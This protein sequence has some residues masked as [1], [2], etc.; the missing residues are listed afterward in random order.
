M[1]QLL[2]TAIAEG[3]VETVESLLE[4][5]DIVHQSEVFDSEVILRFAVRH[6]Q[7]KIVDLLLTK[8]DIDVNTVFRRNYKTALI[9]AVEQNNEELVNLL[10]MRGAKLDNSTKVKSG[11]YTASSLLCNC[12]L[13]GN[14]KIVAILLDNGARLDFT[15]FTE[16]RQVMV[17]IVS[18]NRVD[19]FKMLINAHEDHLFMA[20]LALNHA[21]QEQRAEFIEKIADC[22]RNTRNIT[23]N[24]ISPIECNNTLGVKLLL[25][26]F[27]DLNQ[28]IFFE[29]LQCAAIWAGA[30][31][32]YMLLEARS[33]LDPMC[34]DCPALL[35]LLHSIM[36]LM[37]KLGEIVGLETY[38]NNLKIIVSHIVE[39]L[40]KGGYVKVGKR[41]DKNALLGKFK[42]ECEEELENMKMHKFDE[43]NISLY[44]IW[45]STNL[46]L[47]AYLTNKDVVGSLKLLAPDKLHSSFPIY[48]GRIV[49]R[50]NEGFER[51]F[52]LSRVCNFFKSLSTR[53]EDQVPALPPICTR[54]IFNLLTVTDLVNLRNAYY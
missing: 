10:L 23:V 7:T 52:R 44:D 42:K 19:L 3:N 28:N 25:K 26:R 38:G 45:K 35:V 33:K 8:V 5:P 22:I 24:L 30:E 49:K 11:F 13:G 40:A 15:T 18:K 16:L 41:L 9:M 34:Q 2:Y 4:T 21:V 48:A 29:A 47:P 17:S 6:A 43:T 46:Q 27:I 32:I 39:G 50:L 37:S 31:I 53:K 51:K 36:R 1:K 54:E 12:C 20:S 14:E